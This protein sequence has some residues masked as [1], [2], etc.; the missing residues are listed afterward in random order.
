LVGRCGI[1]SLVMG[2]A[3]AGSFPRAAGE[4]QDGGER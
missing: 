3:L 2:L 4:G 1:L